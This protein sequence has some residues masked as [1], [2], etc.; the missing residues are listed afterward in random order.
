MQLST[1]QRRAVLAAGVALLAIGIA[2]WPPMLQRGGGAQPEAEP[3]RGK[4]PLGF[5]GSGA[6]VGEL[7]PG[8]PPVSPHAAAAAAAGSAYAPAADLTFDAPAPLEALSAEERALLGWMEEQRAPAEALLETLVNID[9]GTHNKAGVDAVATALLAWLQ[10]AGVEAERVPQAS[11]GDHVHAR[12]RCGVSDATDADA[13]PPKRVLLLGHMDTVYADGAAAARPFARSDDGTR[14]WGAGVSDM[15]DGLVAASLI[16]AAAQRFAC[17]GA[18]GPL[19]LEALFTSDEEV[20]SIVSRAGI[21]AAAS[22]ATAVFNM[23]SGSSSGAVAA[24]RKASLT[25]TFVLRGVA[26][27]AGNAPHEGA[28]AVEAF[29]RKALRM[30]ALNDY[31][32]GVPGVKGVDGVT[33]SV[34]TV[35]GGT[36]PNV[37]PDRVTGTVNGRAWSAA[38]LSALREALRGIIE[39]TGDVR[40]TSGEVTHEAL[41]PPFEQTPQRCVYDAACAVADA[42]P[43]FGADRTRL[44]CVRVAALR[45]WSSF[46]APRRRWARRLC[47]RTDE[48]AQR[49][50]RLRP[51]LERPRSAQSAHS[52]TMH[53][54]WTPN[55]CCWTPSCRA[56]S[57]WRLRRCA[58]RSRA[59]RRRRHRQKRRQRRRQHQRRRE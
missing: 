55:F 49:T 35:A 17:A 45:C 36:A 9:S 20:G 33:V 58:W 5:E 51:P 31:R 34:G 47:P 46:G 18:P 23:E 6:A 15:K 1:W 28:S 13:P 32:V 37:V 14:A 44:F 2:P 42:L 56:R 8:H 16:L 21:I 27:H 30:H 57:W 54:T 7:P 25:L 40:G 11:V 22:S 39:D 53:T 48:E 3:A 19:L 43:S 4:C 26:A 52:E 10:R 12:V 29:A 50:P 24:A 59:A 38:R 41:F